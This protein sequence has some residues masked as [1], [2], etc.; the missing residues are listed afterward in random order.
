MTKLSALKDLLVGFVAQQPQSVGNMTVIPLTA[1]D[2]EYHDVG[3]LG[4]VELAKDTDYS[5]LHLRTRRDR[6]VTIVPQGLTYLTKERA[7]DRAVPS[8]H[9]LKGTRQ[10]GAFCVQSSQAGHMSGNR[11]ETRE[12]RLLPQSL[13]YAAF[14]KRE[15]RSYSELWQTLGKFNR[16]SQLGGDFLATFFTHYAGQLDQFVAEFEV[17]PQQRG[18]IILINDEVVGV[19]IAPNQHAFGVLWEPAIRDCYGSEA[20]RA[21]D[22]A[23]PTQEEILGEVEDLEDLPVAV[24]R[25]AQREKARAQRLVMN[26][27]EQGGTMQQTQSLDELTMYSVSTDAFVGFGVQAEQGDGF[28]FLSLMSKPLTARG[29]KF[30]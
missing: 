4:D 5:S 6:G 10:V 11:P 25:M 2:T 27:L 17:I 1:P 19:E 8:A 18:A 14:Q 9:L 15:S 29:F 21:R 30:N 20:L 28:I 16:D 23:K 13:R 26:I 7:Q 22:K 24:D 12:L 3:N